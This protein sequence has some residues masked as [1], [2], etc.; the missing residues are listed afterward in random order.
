MVASVGTG[1]RL[2][3]VVGSIE[4]VGGLLVRS[5]GTVPHHEIGGDGSEERGYY[6]AGATR[7]LGHEHHG[8]EWDPIAGSEHC[9]DSHDEREVIVEAGYDGSG[10]ASE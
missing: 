8:G 1:R 3:G 4:E 9:R 6:E 10:R 7:R 2:V 5:D